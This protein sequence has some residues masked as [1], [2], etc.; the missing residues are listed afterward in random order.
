MRQ[1]ITALL[2]ISIIFTNYAQND[3]E[4]MATKTQELNAILEQMHKKQQFNG[5]VLIAEEG[6][7][8]YE[9]TIGIANSGT[10]EPL[11]PNSS[12]RLASVSKQFIGMGIMILKEKGKL[13]YED[14]IRK[15][16]PELPYQGITIRNLPQSYR[17]LTRL[18]GPFR[19]ALGYH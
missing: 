13:D 1:T 5:T 4:N 10:K 2:W 6:K 12:Y 8:V 3:A 19:N 17:G 14:D 7:V 18:Y 15:H 9:K 11:K 16:I